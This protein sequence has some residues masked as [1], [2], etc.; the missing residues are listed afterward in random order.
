MQ[1]AWA[2]LQKGGFDSDLTFKEALNAAYREF[3]DKNP[4]FPALN[5]LRETDYA[6]LDATKNC[7]TGHPKPPEIYFD[8]TGAMQPGRSHVMKAAELQTGLPLGNPHS[9]NWTSTLATEWVHR[10]EKAVLA[11]M[12]TDES[13]YQV[14]WTPNA[15]GA[16][17]L[18]AEWFDF[19]KSG[20]GAALALAADNHNSVH[21]IREEALIRGAEVAYLP[22][23]P[24]TLH[25]DEEAAAAILEGDFSKARPLLKPSRFPNPFAKKAGTGEKLFAFPLQSNVSGVKHSL[26]WIPYAQERGWLVMAD[27]AAYMPTSFL[28]L[29]KYKPDFMCIS[30]YKIFG[31]PTGVGAL[32]VKKSSFNHLRRKQGWFAGGTISF[33]SV[34]AAGVSV[35]AAHEMGPG[36]ESFEE[37]TVNYSSFIGVYTG[38]Q[39]MKDIEDIGRKFR[40]EIGLESSVE[41]VPEEQNPNWQGNTMLTVQRRVKQLTDYLL[42]ELS[43]LKHPSTSNPLVHI[44]GKTA[45]NDCE[46]GGIIP[47]NVFDSEGHPVWHGLVEE[48]ANQYHISLRTGCFCNPGVHEAYGQLDVEEMA[49]LL[50]RMPQNLRQIDSTR[51]QW[52]VNH[53]INASKPVDHKI[54]LGCVRISIGF[55]ASFPDCFRLVVFFKSLLTLDLARL[56]SKY[57]ADD[58]Q[59]INLHP[60]SE[61]EESSEAVE[62]GDVIGV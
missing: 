14:I 26:D 15:S 42:Q 37:G 45:L 32:V 13:E 8:Y 5:S 43:E 6:Q 7:E 4:D 35:Q 10:A 59:V 39:Y 11:H 61:S 19:G 16:C 31:H 52:E 38:L 21:G 54:L 29:S 17:R 33:N 49:K 44:Y 62:V 22:M 51:S 40:A 55:P 53:A 30:F 9:T 28:D 57:E 24:E 56:N 60:I 46:R 47:L 12:N 36:K 2:R 3:V 1:R 41:V 50:R 25:L 18:V 58:F 20:S 48:L 27:A 23:D 34:L